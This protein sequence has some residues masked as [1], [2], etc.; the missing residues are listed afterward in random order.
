MNKKG[1]LRI[2]EAILAIVIV[3][4]FVISIIP[5]QVKDNSKFPPDLDQT[6]DSI[7]KEMQGNPKFRECV[8][9]GEAEITRIEN[10][11]PRKQILNSVKCVH[12]YIEYLSYPP[13]TSPWNYAVRICNFN[14]TAV[15][16]NCIYEPT[17]QRGNF[18]SE[19]LPLDKDVYIKDTALTVPDVSGIPQKSQGSGNYSLLTIYA[20]SKQ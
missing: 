2:L 15:L 11:I 5:S 8:L 4:G 13:A 10:G 1:F 6:I 16:N 17:P 19:V 12:G 14:Q 20:W 9:G 3:L 7:F 18:E